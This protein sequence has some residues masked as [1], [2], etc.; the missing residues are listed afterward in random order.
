MRTYQWCFICL[1]RLSLSRSLSIYTLMSWAIFLWWFIILNIWSLKWI[2]GRVKLWAHFKYIQRHPSP[3]FYKHCR[4]EK[5][6][7]FVHITNDTRLDKYFFVPLVSGVWIVFLKVWF[8][9][10][11][12]WA[13]RISHLWKDRKWANCHSTWP[14]LEHILKMCLMLSELRDNG[15]RFGVLLTDLWL[16]EKYGLLPLIV[17]SSPRAKKAAGVSGSKCCWWLPYPWYY[18]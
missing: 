6:T 4:L 15:S 14:P 13:G 5:F 7:S 12:L 1:Q 10:V 8:L 18:V 3:A 2:G 17:S 9:L 11:V 16:G